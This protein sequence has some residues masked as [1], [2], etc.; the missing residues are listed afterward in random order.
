VLVSFAGLPERRR[1]FV[2]FPMA[3]VVVGDVVVV[4]FLGMVAVVSAAARSLARP[5]RRLG[6]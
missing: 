4:L 3:A 2:H 1:R 6:S 5:R